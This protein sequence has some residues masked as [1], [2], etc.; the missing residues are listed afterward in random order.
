[1]FYICDADV[2]TSTKAVTGNL[3]HPFPFI[4]FLPFLLYFPSFRALSPRVEVASQI[5][6]R[7]LAQSAVSSLP[8]RGEGGERLALTATNACL[9]AANVVLFRLNEV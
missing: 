5:Q 4:F 3:S 8:S 1:M 6:L 2:S 7:D 9:V